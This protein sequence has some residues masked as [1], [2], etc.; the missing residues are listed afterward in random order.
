MTIEYVQEYFEAE[1]GDGYKADDNRTYID[2]PLATKPHLDIAYHI[3]AP[4]RGKNSNT[5]VSTLFGSFMGNIYEETYRKAGNRV[6]HFTKASNFRDNVKSIVTVD[7]PMLFTTWH[8]ERYNILKDFTYRQQTNIYYDV[9]G[10]YFFVAMDERF[11]D[12]FETSEIYYQEDHRNEKIKAQIKNTKDNKE[13]LIIYADTIEELKKEIEEDGNT[14]DILHKRYKQ[15]FL[16]LQDLEKVIVLRY[17]TE[18]EDTLKNKHTNQFSITNNR[19]NNAIDFIMRQ[20]MAM[21]MFQAAKTDDGFYYLIDENTSEIQTKAI[22]YIDED[23]TSI[24]YINQ[25]KNC[26]YG[27]YKGGSTFLIMPYSESDWDMLKNIQNRLHSICRELESILQSSKTEVGKLD[28]PISSLDALT[29][30][31]PLFL[32]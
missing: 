9:K 10:Q 13:L 14:F 15:R 27:T 30:N 21:E 25:E 26:E 6:F 28:K 20:N 11:F 24:E 17:E 29:H 7:L 1:N 23:K 4:N 16:N 18:N 8:I 22:I 32:N 31:K 2:A 3:A 19:D 5:V 12:N